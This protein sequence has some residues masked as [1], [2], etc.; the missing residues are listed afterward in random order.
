MGRAVSAVER[1]VEWELRRC[2]DCGH[3]ANPR[4]TRPD[5]LGELPCSGCQSR[6]MVTVP[7]IPLGDAAGVA[8]TLREAVTALHYAAVRSRDL[9]DQAEHS[10]VQRARFEGRALAFEEALDIVTAA[11]PLRTGSEASE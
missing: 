3:E 2:L 6:N 8:F 11:D 10:P 5:R 7:L 9:A 4:Q 1:Q